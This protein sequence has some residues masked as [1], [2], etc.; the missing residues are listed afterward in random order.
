MK[1]IAYYPGCT[2]KT[3]ARNLDETLTASLKALGVDFHELERWNCCGAAFSLADDNLLTLVAPARNLIRVKEL[4][5]DTVMTACSLCYNS[6]ARVNLVMRDDEEKRETLNS[7]MEE[8]IDY[9]GEVKVIHLLNLLKE[10]IGWQELRNK[11]SN[12]LEGIKVAPY[13][14]CLLIR[15]T[16][17]AIDTR[18]YPRIFEEYLEALGAE[19]IDFAAA[20]ECCGSYQVVS[21]PDLAV[22]NCAHILKS[23][24]EN[25]ADMIVS[26]C[27]LCE[28]NLGAKQGEVRSKHPEISGV[29]TFYFTQ[30]LAIALGLS[31]EICHFEL[32][33]SDALEFLKEKNLVPA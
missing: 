33:M 10:E 13:Y 29:P 9:F 8:E 18:T 30:L 4:G 25:G 23:V 7:F 22:E 5:L 1:K 27:P 2:L 28:F 20:H 21:N 6:L 32:N 15:P 17:I 11:I 14:G 12:P 16:E 26:S 3:K 19:V 24:G 31:P